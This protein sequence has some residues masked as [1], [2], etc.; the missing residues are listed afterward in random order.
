MA[1]RHSLRVGGAW[2]YEIGSWG[3][4][5]WS[6]RWPL[7]CY[8]ASW[9]MILRPRERPG[10]IHVGALVEI[11]DGSTR[12]WKGT[13]GEPNWSEG[14]FTATGLYALGSQYMAL[15]SAGN[16]S[17]SQTAAVDAAISRGLP[18]THGALSTVPVTTLTDNINTIAQLND[19]V[20]ER[21]SVTAPW[22]WMVDENGVLSNLPDP[23][24]VTWHLAPGSVDLGESDGDF[25]SALQV[26][27]LDSSTSTYHT[28][29]VVDTTLANAYG[30][31]ES[32]VDLTPLG[33]ITS[34]TA[35][36]YGQGILTREK[37][38]IGWTESIEATALQLTTPGGMPADL[39]SVRARDLI[40]AFDVPTPLQNLPYVDLVVGE[41]VYAA[42]ADVVRLSPVDKQ[43]QTLAEITEDIVRK[44]RPGF[45][46]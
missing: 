31:V 44:T 41:A 14:T 32:P 21:A 30:Y 9:S 19:A 6:T 39:S 2:A 20:N 17:S 38:R 33:P 12:I 18:W 24:V 45:R 7:G 29:L 11:Y 26:R 3:D 22:R 42:G 28:N 43:P 46:G 25:A 27:Y 10:V 36:Q 40:R 16:S 4:L 13:L 37:G 8:E 23:T 5:Q 1:A 34:A 35:N 15:D